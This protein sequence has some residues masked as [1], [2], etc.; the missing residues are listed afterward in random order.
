MTRERDARVCEFWKV[1]WVTNKKVIIIER[2]VDGR[3]WKAIHPCSQVGQ[4]GGYVQKTLVYKDVKLMGEIWT[5][6]VDLGI[7]GI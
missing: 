2:K 5:G 6:D 7:I 1:D 4:S 3:M